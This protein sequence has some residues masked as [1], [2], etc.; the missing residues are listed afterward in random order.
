MCSA[1]RFGGGG[2]RRRLKV[3]ANTMAATTTPTA[4]KKNGISSPPKRLTTV[5]LPE[6]TWSPNSSGGKR[7]LALPRHGP[8]DPVQISAFSTERSSVQ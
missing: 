6:L 3:K 4:I 1:D 5:S 8:T 7:Q 2:D